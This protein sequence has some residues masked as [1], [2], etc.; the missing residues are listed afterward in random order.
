[1][2]SSIAQTNI[3]CSSQ[4]ITNMCI[5]CLT[6]YIICRFSLPY[7]ALLLSLINDRV[8]LINNQTL[9]RRF[10]T[11]QFAGEITKLL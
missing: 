10:I 4:D 11:D 3:L 1:M 5:P 8:E 2:K 9:L 6:P 7:L